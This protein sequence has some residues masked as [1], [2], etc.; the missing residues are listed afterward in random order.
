MRRLSKAAT[1][2]VGLVLAI[3]SPGFAADAPDLVELRATLANPSL[4]VDDRAR[5]ALEGVTSIDQAAQ[6]SAAP[7]VRRKLW[8]QATGLLDEFLARNPTVGSSPLIRFQAGVYRWAEGRSFAQE[9]ELSPANAQARAGAVQALED[10]IGRLRAVGLKSVDSADPLAQNVR[11]RLAQAIADR[12]R[13]EPENELTRMASEREALAMLDSSM[14]A[15]GL[16]AF[17]RLLRAELANRLRLYGQAQ[18]EI[19]EA[20]KLTPPPPA[21]DVLEAKVAAMT[22]RE[23]FTDARSLVASSKINEDL[24]RLLTLR[25]VLGRRRGLPPG[26][27]RKEVDAEAFQI[28]RPMAGSGRPEAR[29][30][31]M[32]LA[33]TVDEPAGDAAPETW[34]LLAEGHL[35]LGD[36][37]RAGRLEAKGAER[38]DVI[39]LVDQAA[40]LRY[41][42][43]AC[44]FEAEKFAEADRWLSRVVETPKAPRDLRGRAG[45]LRALARGRALATRQPGASRSSYQQGLESQVRDF[46]DEPAT[47]EARWLLGQLRLASGRPE[48]A[49]ALFS[50]IRHGQPRWL[51]ARLVTADLLREAVEVQTINRDESA[52]R[53]KMEAARKSLRSESDSASPGEESVALMLKLDRLELTPVAGDPSEAIDVCDRLLKAAASA[54]VHRLARLYRVVAQAQAGR[55]IEAEQAARVESRTGTPTD[56]LPAL[57]PLGRSAAEADS[58]ISRRRLGLILRIFTSRM[59][60]RIDEVPTAD[61]DQVRLQHARALLFSGDLPASRREVISWGGPKDPDDPELLRDLADLYS[62]LEAFELVIDVE[63]LRAGRLATGSLPW[64]EAR[65]GLALAYYRSD[66]AKEARQVIDATAI[67]HSELGGGDLRGRFERLRQK[68]GND[69]R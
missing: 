53:A 46:P 19:E 37:T 40:S 14:T 36:A 1:L 41:K 65:Y 35:R 61:R 31:L 25:I 59:I 38:A 26:R 12:A 15:P 43:G 42:A 67:L 28:A 66:R 33:R 63:R 20:E 23:L 55:W 49:V 68:L 50:A 2:A 16:R 64:L 22:G 4:S 58:E 27:D 34:D 32:E 3:E 6:E 17:A 11:F 62:R 8:G 39:G 18:M 44:L 30:G 60:D 9:F 13:L 47:G 10:A 69:R 52:T 51:D 7:A 45:M 5:R 54:D 24:K 56:L 48:D 29:R 21:V 57:R